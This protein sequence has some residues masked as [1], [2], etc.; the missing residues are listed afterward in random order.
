MGNQKAVTN[1]TKDTRGVECIVPIEDQM[2]D[3]RWV[4][5]LKH[6]TVPMTVIGAATE[7]DLISGVQFSPK[8]NRPD[9][10]PDQPIPHKATVDDPAIIWRL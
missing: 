6:R 9:R 7:E 1:R 3:H 8:E 2:E 5:A 10:V 4:A